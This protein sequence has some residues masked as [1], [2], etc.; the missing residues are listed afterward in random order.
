MSCSHFGLDSLEKIDVEAL[1]LV[2]E[3]LQRA[4]DLIQLVD[5]HAQLLDCL[6]FCSN[7]LEKLMLCVSELTNII[8]SEFG[9]GLEKILRLGANRCSKSC[10]LGLSQLDLFV[11]FLL[12]LA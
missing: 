8:R 3:I 10:A 2:H 9:L 7:I 6:S 5:L 11:E 1:D 4:V 12:L